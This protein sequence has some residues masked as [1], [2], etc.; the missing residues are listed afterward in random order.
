MPQIKELKICEEKL[1]G[2]INKLTIV[3]EILNI[4]LS[5]IDNTTRQKIRKIVDGLVGSV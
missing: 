5:T 1:K 4:P 3:V 2:K